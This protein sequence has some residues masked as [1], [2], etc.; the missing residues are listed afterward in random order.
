MPRTTRRLE[1][2]SVV[3]ACSHCSHRRQLSS[4]GTL[5]VRDADYLYRYFSTLVD[6]A[7]F[8]FT[9]PAIRWP[10]FNILCFRH[11]PCFYH[12]GWTG[13][14]GE[15]NIILKTLTK[16]YQRALAPIQANQPFLTV[17]HSIGNLL[18]IASIDHCYMFFRWRWRWWVTF[19]CQCCFS[20]QL[21]WMMA[22]PSLLYFNSLHTQ[23]SHD[24]D[25]LNFSTVTFTLKNHINVST[26]FFTL[27]FK[28]CSIYGMQIPLGWP[29]HH[30][31]LLT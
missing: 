22:T 19:I 15:F 26:L 7:S 18:F 25:T 4:C 24:S 29:S 8:I 27:Q 17:H 3:Y 21:G 20:N 13:S 12:Y 31:I 14:T 23:P 6:L 9:C 16:P 30:P 10:E 5:V 2:C 28:L 1:A 11:F